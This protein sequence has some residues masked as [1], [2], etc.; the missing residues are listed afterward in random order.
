MKKSLLLFTLLL[1]STVTSFAQKTCPGAPI[2]FTIKGSTLD[3][4]KDSIKENISLCIER[5]KARIAVADGK[6]DNFIL[7]HMLDNISSSP[8]FL[9]AHN[10]I[11]EYEELSG[12]GFLSVKALNNNTSQ[13]I[14]EISVFHN[15]KTLIIPVRLHDNSKEDYSQLELV[16]LPN[17]GKAPCIAIYRNSA[18]ES[19][20]ESTIKKEL[21]NLYFFRPGNSSLL[22]LYKKGGQESYLNL[23]INSKN[24]D[25]FYNA[26]NVRK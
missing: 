23:L 5:G 4:N 7:Y 8:D 19:L 15:G 24:A 20:K 21:L 25:A 2:P 16:N 13:S 22:E 3:I 14:T 12:Y 9:S 1:F 10:F 18:N 11:V 26:I 6:T 17:C